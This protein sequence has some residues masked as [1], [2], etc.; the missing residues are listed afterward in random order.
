MRS[1]E[2]VAAITSTDSDLRP[3]ALLDAELAD[4]RRGDQAVVDRLDLVR[5]VAPQPGVA[6][7]VH[8][9]LHAR[10]PLGD[11][12]GRQ[13]VALGRHDRA[14]PAGLLRGQTGEPLRAA[15]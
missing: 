13:L 15:R 5:T 12:A 14:V 7:L 9:V 3:V 6:V 10:T 8:R 4:A 11:F 1:W 2:P